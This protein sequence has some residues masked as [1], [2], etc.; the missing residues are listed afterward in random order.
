MGITRRDFLIS[1][2]GS[3]WALSRGNSIYADGPVLLQNLVYPQDLATPLKYFDRLITPNEIFF[4]RSHF[5]PPALKPDRRLLVDGM[6]T[7]SNEFTAD[8]LRD[9]FEEVSVTAVLQC[10]GN[11][12]ALHTPRMPGLQWVDGAMG[13]AKWTGVRLRDV[14][15][16][17]GV[18][19]GAAYV[20]LLGADL[21]PV[22]ATPKYLR[23]I[24]LDR[25]MDPSTLLAYKMNDEPLS[26]SHGAPLRLVVPGWAGD[27]WMKW[28]QNV[29]VAA[30]EPRGFYYETGYR[31]PTEP[32]PPGVPVPP[33][34]MAPLT[35]MPVRSVIAR[36]TDGGTSP[37]GKQEVVGIAF[38]G[39]SAISK[40]E[41][42]VDGGTTWNK[43]ALDGDPGPGRWQ[44]FRHTFDAGKASSHT[45]LARATDAA[46]NTQPR[47]VSWNPSGYFWNGW[48]SVS[49]NVA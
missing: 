18:K 47:D 9:A 15:Q 3:A 11:G 43:A 13:Q 17:A 2:V 30:K 37:R 35:V 34:K 32:V 10:A 26:L 14:L 39:G 16:K 48:H 33:E 44:V 7:T 31:M 23:G 1:A 6:V 42:S 41:V 24:P 21:P 38:S 25:A 45:A 29:R 4:V 8:S 5:G 22:P 19:P 49:W 12:R 40:V 36:P 20:H 46:G 27:H 28:L